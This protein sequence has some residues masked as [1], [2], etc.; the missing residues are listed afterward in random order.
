MF[1]E[2]PEKKGPEGEIQRS[3]VSALRQREW[4]VME[5]HGNLYQ[6]GFPDLY[7][8]HPTHGQRWIEVKLPGMKGSKF[9]AAQIKYFKLMNASGIGVWIL[10]GN[11]DMEMNKLFQNLTKGNWE[12]YYIQYIQRNTR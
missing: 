12:G 3:I 10:T 4:T 9:T 6:R 8:F 11:T 5:T 7:C 1:I 2:L